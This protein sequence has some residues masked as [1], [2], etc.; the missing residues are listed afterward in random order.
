ME[1]QQF[2]RKLSQR[3]KVLAIFMT[4]LFLIL[5]SENGLTQHA[6]QAES[7]AISKQM[8][9][10]GKVSIKGSEPHTYLCLSTDSGIDYRLTGE[11][12]DMIWARF[13]QEMMTLEGVVSKEALGP[14]FPAAFTVHKIVKPTSK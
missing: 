14:G 9:I 5:G 7:A 4:F 3:V 8:Q 13:Q 2:Q 11:L 6:K 1:R 10:K 12:K